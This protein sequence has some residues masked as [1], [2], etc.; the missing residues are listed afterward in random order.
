VNTVVV[1]SNTPWPHS[2]SYLLIIKDNFAILLST[3]YQLGDQTDIPTWL[4]FEI[5]KCEMI[6]LTVFSSIVRIR[7]IIFTSPIIYLYSGDF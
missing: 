6:K 1:P 3:V 7:V 2:K 4:C 5:F